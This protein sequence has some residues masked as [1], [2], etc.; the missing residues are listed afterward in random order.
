MSNHV[1]LYGT[2]WCPYCVRARNLLNSK[3][4]EFEDI[5]VSS[6]PE[7]RAKM[8]AMSGETSV[9]QI[10]I[11]DRHIGGCDELY[12]LEF[13]GALDALLSV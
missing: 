2:P 8:V 3:G 4:V 11:G 9:P 5:N 7:L 1:V 12:E 6:A 13:I 10:W